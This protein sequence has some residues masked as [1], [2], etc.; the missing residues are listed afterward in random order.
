MIIPIDGI[1][2]FRKVNVITLEDEMGSYDRVK[3]SKCEI[4]GKLRN[5]TKVHI[6]GRK[7]R[8]ARHCN[9]TSEEI[10]RTHVNSL[11][12]DSNPTNV[13]CPNCGDEVHQ[14]IQWEEEGKRGIIS[15]ISA[16]CRCGF[17][18]FLNV[19]ETYK[20]WSK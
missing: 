5:F 3:C 20:T 8:K 1:H 2:D 12:S 9:Q 16:V 10:S 18:G 14:H 6:D 19:D 13:S 4:E 17:N 7:K 15:M 11:L